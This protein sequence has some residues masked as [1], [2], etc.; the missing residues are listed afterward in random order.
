MGRKRSA[1]GQRDSQKGRGNFKQG[2]RSTQEAVREN[3]RQ[4]KRG[5]SGLERVIARDLH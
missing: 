3:V 1:E 5:F 2:E 4:R